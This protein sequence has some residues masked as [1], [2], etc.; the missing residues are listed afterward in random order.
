MFKKI[1]DVLTFCVAFVKTVPEFIFV[2]GS[3]LCSED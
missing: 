2:C 3:L 1:K